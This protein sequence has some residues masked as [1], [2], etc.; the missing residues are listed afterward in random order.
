M[1]E[2]ITSHLRPHARRAYFATRNAAS[3]ALIERRAGVNTT[4]EV[5]LQDLGLDATN[6]VRYEPSGWLDLRRIL[7]PNDVSHDDVFID[8]G[9]G[10]GRVLLQAARYEFGR[11]IGVELSP[12]LADVARANIAAA[13]HRRR[14]PDVSVVTSDVLAYEIPDDLTYAYLYNPFRGELFAEFIGRL[15]ESFDRNPRRLHIIYKT[16]IEAEYLE[17][18]GRVRLVR[19]VRGIRPGRAWAEKMSIRLYEV[20]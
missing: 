19:S 3:R 11:V 14:C 2:S 10:K 6:R 5:N 13:Q 1:T 9:A 15:V 18:T 17:G 16:P 12:V 8:F 7:R 20:R 4:G